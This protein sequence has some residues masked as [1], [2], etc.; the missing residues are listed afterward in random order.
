[1]VDVSVLGYFAD[2]A[3]IVLALLDFIELGQHS[4]HKVLRMVIV[5]GANL[6]VSRHSVAR[7]QADM[8]KRI[9]VSLR[10]KNNTNTRGEM[11]R[12]CTSIMKD[13]PLL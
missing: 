8:L 4:L 2:G 1:M 7:K 12:R 10:A 11:K 9:V 3:T 5:P 6:D 13:L